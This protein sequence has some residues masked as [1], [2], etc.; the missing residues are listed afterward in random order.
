MNYKNCMTYNL[1]FVVK[2]LLSALL[3]AAATNANA[4][5]TFTL[6]QAIDEACASNADLQSKRLDALAAMEQKKEL[7]T[8]YFPNV[9]ATATYFERNT[10]IGKGSAWMQSLFQ[11]VA[12]DEDYNAEGLDLMHRGVVAG[13]SLVQ[14]IYTGGRLTSANKMAAIGEAAAGEMTALKQNQ[15]KEEVEKYFWQLVQLYEADRSLNTLD[16]LVSQARHD[17]RV[18]FRAGVVTVADTMQVDIH[19]SQLR[20]THLQVTNGKQLCK[21]YL[22]YLMGV[23]RV[24]SIV[25]A[26]IYDVRQPDT[27]RTDPSAALLDRHETRLL[28]MQ[29][30]VAKW[31]RKFTMG[32]LLPTVGA[33][34]SFNYHHFFAYNDKGIFHKSFDTHNTGWLAMASVRV[35]ITAWWGGRHSLR[36]ADMNIQ[37]AQLE[38]DNKQRLMEVQ[39]SMKWNTLNEKYKQI[40]VARQQLRQATQNQ[41][42]QAVAYRSGAITMTSRLQADALYEQ[43][44][45]N[46]IDACVKYRLAI[47]DYLH[48]TGR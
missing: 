2:T 3:C 39:M 30:D 48:A 4:Q 38:R 33:M 40:D 23:E 8:K 19:A 16:S 20:S 1:S 26:D 44:R 15:V 17:A 18:A 29:L 36:R 11:L 25:W 37:K 27:Y 21:D 45:N 42:Q 13:V 46:Y 5:A 43:S 12:G 32:S 41:K 28:Q 35:P 7:Y 47:A 24:D 14:P 9:S 34:F 10:G 31:R 6:Q 22:A